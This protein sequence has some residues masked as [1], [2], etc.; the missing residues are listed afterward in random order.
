MVRRPC[1][2]CIKQF[3][4]GGSGT[5]EFTVENRKNRWKNSLSRHFSRF[6]RFDFFFGGLGGVQPQGGSHAAKVPGPSP[7]SGSDKERGRR[8]TGCLARTSDADA[9]L[10]GR[11]KRC[12]GSAASTLSAVPRASEVAAGFSGFFACGAMPRNRAHRIKRDAKTNAKRWFR[13]TRPRNR[14]H[15]AGCPTCRNLPGARTSRFHLYLTSRRTYTRQARGAST[16]RYSGCT[17]SCITG[18]HTR[19]GPM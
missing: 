17:A 8:N 3:R 15:Q 18:D 6:F 11:R 5:P 14:G 2:F 9:A 12:W 16:A 10:C 4:H 7:Q 1:L 13:N 19:S